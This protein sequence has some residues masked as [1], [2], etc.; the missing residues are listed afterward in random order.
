MQTMQVRNRQY[1]EIQP[2]VWQR[3]SEVPTVALSV[4]APSGIGITLM[5]LGVLLISTLAVL[6]QVI[7]RKKQIDSEITELMEVTRI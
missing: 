4:P 6:P 1:C 3:C 7:E 2:A 5:I